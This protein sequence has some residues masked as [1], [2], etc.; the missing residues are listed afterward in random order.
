[1]NTS[2]C[3]KMCN[4]VQELVFLKISSL[5][6]LGVRIPFSVELP[7]SMQLEWKRCEE[8]SNVGLKSGEM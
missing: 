4:S 2:L 6:K 1:M 3:N 8:K 7:V 5:K